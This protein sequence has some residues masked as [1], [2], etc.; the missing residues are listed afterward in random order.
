MSGRGMAQ[1]SI[2]LIE[3]SCRI[4]AAIHPTSSRGV[5]YQLFIRASNNSTGL[6]ADGSGI[7]LRVAHSVVTGNGVG[8]NRFVD[9][10]IQSYGNNDI[11]GNTSDNTGVLT[12]LT[13]H[14]PRDSRTRGIP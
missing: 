12:P 8:V 2:D 11:D 14:L 13:M 3:H 1:K 4:L 5:A 10:T 7:V 9:G 6:E